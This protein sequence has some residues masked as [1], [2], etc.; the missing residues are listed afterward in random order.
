MSRAKKRSY[1]IWRPKE[2]PFGI[3]WTP[4]QSGSGSR[5]PRRAADSDARA[6]QGYEL[7]GDAQSSR[8]LL[9]R[10]KVGN[11]QFR[12]NWTLLALCRCCC[13][14][15]S[16]RRGWFGRRVS[17]RKLRTW[18][19]RARG[20]KLPKKV[21]HTTLSCREKVFFLNPAR[22]GNDD[23]LWMN[24]PA[25]TRFYWQWAAQER[26]PGELI[27]ICLLLERCHWPVMTDLEGLD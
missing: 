8:V 9:F 24:L 12:L 7:K 4:S 5:D 22:V 6:S 18:R 3:F 23:A 17:L 27:C 20:L 26:Q 25:A 15:F 2:K 19:Q 10:C 14:S 16:H 13:S 1:R 21:L 11:L